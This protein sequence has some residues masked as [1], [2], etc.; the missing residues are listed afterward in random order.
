MFS[1]IL[2]PALLTLGV[3]LILVSI[4][5]R[6][7]E[8]TKKVRMSRIAGQPAKARTGGEGEYMQ[9]ESGYE[10]YD[11]FESRSNLSYTLEKFLGLVG[12][13]YKNFEKEIRT[14]FDQAGLSMTIGGLIN[15]VFFKKF[16]LAIGVLVALLLLSSGPKA[17]AMRMIT[18]LIAGIIVLIGW[19]GADGY[20]KNRKEKRQYIL[21][22]S[23]PDALDL[24]LVCVEAGLAL[25]AALSRVTKELDSAHP[26][27]T[28]ELNKTRIELTL[29]NDRPKAL[30][31]LAERT[32]MVAFRALVSALL[33]SEKF[34]TS[35]TDT[36]RVLSEDFRNTRMLVAENKANR[37]PALMTIPLMVFM[38]PALVMVLMG[39]AIIMLMHSWGGVGK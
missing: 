10:E 27:I 29:L 15:Y 24:I 16:G 18:F 17:G 28:K 35:L 38:M 7:N 33:Q 22:R 14:K 37:L 13:D 32:D 19:K 23:F 34:G 20:L 5:G 8:Q 12:V 3:V 9:E 4:F 25:D 11:Q 21:Q 31:N 39:P 2:L 30:H 6:K 1:S 36:L 26:E